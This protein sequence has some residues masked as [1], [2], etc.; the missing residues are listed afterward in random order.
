MAAP[1]SPSRRV[2]VDKTTNATVQRQGLENNS[3]PTIVTKA[4][5][6]EQLGKNIVNFQGKGGPRV[7]E[8]RS[9]EHMMEGSEDRIKM[10]NFIDF[11]P[12]GTEEEDLE[13]MQPKPI[14]PPSEHARKA[15]IQDVSSDT[16]FHVC[17]CLLTPVSRK[18]RHSGLGSSLLSSKFRP[19]RPKHLFIGCVAVDRLQSWRLCLVCRESRPKRVWFG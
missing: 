6:V 12:A 17:P 18:Q 7:G 11:D 1:A 2:L 3:K 4:S 5:T 14:L 8:K 15:M 19:I 9:I 16:A 10:S 13:M